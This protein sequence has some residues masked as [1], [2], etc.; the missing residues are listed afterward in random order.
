ML[1]EVSDIRSCGGWMRSGLANI[2][3]A[4]SGV[5][6]PVANNCGRNRQAKLRPA[7]LL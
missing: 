4:G 5:R 3:P 6:S 7:M 1:A 2:D